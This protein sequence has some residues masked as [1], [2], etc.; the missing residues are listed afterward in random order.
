MKFLAK[1][2]TAA[3][4]LAVSV[5]LSGCVNGPFYPWER[6]SPD[7]PYMIGCYYADP[8]TSYHPNSFYRCHNNRCTT[9]SPYAPNTC[10]PVPYYTGCKYTSCCQ[11][12]IYTN[13]F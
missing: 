11:Q 4:P 5:L 2:V 12:Q 10:D 9:F 8:C 1:L 7:A 13:Y 6:C 3:S